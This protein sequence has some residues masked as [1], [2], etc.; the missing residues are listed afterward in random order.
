MACNR[1]LALRLAAVALLA[2]AASPVQAQEAPRPAPPPSPF[3]QLNIGV[4]SFTP[5]LQLRNIGFDSNALDLAATEPV[6][7]DFTATIEPGVE[8]RFATP[9]LDLRVASTVAMTYYQQHASER[10]VSPNFAAT[11]DH[12]LS[13]SLALYGKGNIGFI[14]ERIGFEIDT[15]PRRLTHGAT[16]GARIGQR[17]IEL[18]LH[19]TL[20]GV[21]FDPDAS[22]QQFSMAKTMNH[23]FAGVGG[24]VKYR[25][26]PYTALTTGVDATATRFEFSP[27]R[28]TNSY[29]GTVGVEFHPRAM[30]SGTAGLGYRVLSPKS[31]RTPAFSGFTPRAGL[32]Y[33]L[34]D[35]LT[36]SGGAQRDV[37]YSVYNDRPYFLYTLYEGSVRKVLFHRFDIGGSIQ[38]T[39]LDY[40]PFVA[41]GGEFAAL[42]SEVVRMV[43]ASLGVPILRKF[44]VGWYVQR[45]DRVSGDR[46]YQTVR[47]GF[48]IS[49]G[50]A[51]VSP[52]GVFLSGP[53]R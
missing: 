42:P 9:R 26:S 35:S 38:H 10:A 31:D 15:R 16:A 36:I 6:D 40:Q 3:G 48:E 17:K 37:E 7:S 52:R 24:G 18:D 27:L 51:S 8:T 46:P 21:S 5:T 43:T 4:V 49:V 28:D 47:T 1:S 32:T 19:A 12:R 29:S 13:G 44:R 2:A 53:G 14:K 39:T 23:R 50:K 45:W 25:L 41:E 20:G 34:H 11:L 30:I 22:F 33:T